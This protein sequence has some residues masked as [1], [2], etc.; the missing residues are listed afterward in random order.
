MHN[1]DIGNFRRDKVSQAK[2][3]ARGLD[4]ESNL[5]LLTKYQL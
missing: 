2:F 3:E 5:N 1:I 4:S